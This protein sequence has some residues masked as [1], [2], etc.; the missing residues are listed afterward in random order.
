MTLPLLLLLVPYNTPRSHWLTPAL[1]LSSC[2]YAFPKV[3]WNVL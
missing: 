2:G 1:V 3:L